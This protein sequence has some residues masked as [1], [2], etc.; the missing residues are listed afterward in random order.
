M[1]EEIRTCVNIV[2]RNAALVWKTSPISECSANTT[3]G[4]SL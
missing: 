1:Q 4:F 3:V 2:V